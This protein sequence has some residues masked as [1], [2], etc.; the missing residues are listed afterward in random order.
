LRAKFRSPE[1]YYA[2]AF[3]EAG[4]STGHPDRLNRPGIADFDHFGSG[5]YAREELVARDDLIDAARQTGIDS[6]EVFGN[7]VSYIAGW[8]HVLGND[9]R[10]VITATAHAQRACDVIGQPERQAARDSDRYP[11][12]APARGGHMPIETTAASSDQRQA[13]HGPGERVTNTGDRCEPTTQPPVAAVPGTR[14]ST[15]PARA[16]EKVAARTAPASSKDRSL[17]RAAGTDETR[18]RGGDRTV[19][20]QRPPGRRSDRRRARSW[21][22]IRPSRRNRACPDARPTAHPATTAAGSC[23]PRSSPAWMGSDVASVMTYIRTLTANLREAILT[24]RVMGSIAEHNA[25]RQR[26][27]G[28]WVRAAA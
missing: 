10:L 5:K 26:P 18:R 6:L 12:A 15:A 21:G 22:L 1:H 2:T 8:L 4:H 17:D 25:A 11:E 27:D 7:S 24:E 13:N 9:E 23:P 28:V 19:T 3:H 14:L 20:R 16:A